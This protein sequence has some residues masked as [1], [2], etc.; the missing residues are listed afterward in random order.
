MD[1]LAENRRLMEDENVKMPDM[2]REL[3]NTF[4]YEEI[5]S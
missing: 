4:L 2:S 3:E 1:V 5:H